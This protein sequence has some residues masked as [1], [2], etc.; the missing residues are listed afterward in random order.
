[1]VVCGSTIGWTQARTA[2]WLDT[3][4]PVSWNL[5]GSPVPA[6]PRTDPAIDPRCRSQAR[7]SQLSEDRQLRDKGWDLV[8]P[9][10]G[11]WQVLVIRATASYDGMCRPRQYQ[12]FVFARGV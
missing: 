5:P 7:P 12:D 4:K 6:A 1:M 9:F 2:S 11:G 10:T 8:G 3:Q